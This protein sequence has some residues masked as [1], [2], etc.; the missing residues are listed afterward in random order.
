MSPVK[1]EQNLD[2]FM[3]KVFLF[4]K[5]LGVILFAVFVYHCYYI[6]KLDISNF[7]KIIYIIINIIIYPLVYLVTTIIS[8]HLVNPFISKEEGVLFK[9]HEV[10]GFN[11]TNVSQV[12]IFNKLLEQNDVSSNKDKVE[13]TFGKLKLFWEFIEKL[14][15]SEFLELPNNEEEYDK[16]QK[17]V[18]DGYKTLLP[19]GLTLFELD[20]IINFLET[21]YDKSIAVSVLYV[22]AGLEGGSILECNGFY[23]S[24]IL[25]SQAFDYLIKDPDLFLIKYGNNCEVNEYH[26]TRQIT[27][28]EYAVTDAVKEFYNIPEKLKSA[29]FFDEDVENWVFNKTDFRVPILK[30]TLTD[31]GYCYT[32]PCQFVFLEKISDKIVSFIDIAEFDDV[33]EGVYDSVCN[34]DEDSEVILYIREGKIINGKKI[35]E[36][37]N[38]SDKKSFEE[39]LELKITDGYVIVYQS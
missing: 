14:K 28:V 23:H 26:L 17:I 16:Y 37:Y 38:F 8:A 4:L 33:S 21:I 5:V 10:K 25:G 29:E 39:L 24:V 13:I 31:A 11:I 7:W 32:T 6:F 35:V 19:T 15:K 3:S 27:L 36:N 34:V 2:K 30:P 20:C 12:D 22:G 18:L 1:Y 9:S